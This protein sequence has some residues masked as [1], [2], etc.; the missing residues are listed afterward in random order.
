[1][2]DGTGTAQTT[3]LAPLPGD[4]CGFQDRANMRPVPCDI[5]AALVQ[6]LCRR[7]RANLPT[8]IF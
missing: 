3:L 8:L 1:M 5:R 7:R 6:I 4:R 2:E